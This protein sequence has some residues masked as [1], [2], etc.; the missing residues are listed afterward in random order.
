VGDGTNGPVA[1]PIDRGPFFADTTFRGA[2]RDCNWLNGWS[3]LNAWGTMSETNNTTI[4]DVTLDR[5]S[6][7][8]I[9]K[10]PTVSGVQYSV[11]TSTDNKRYN[12]ATT[13]T[14]TGSAAAIDLGASTT[15]KFVRV[16]P[17]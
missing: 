17:L 16:L 11:E 3:L 8:L 9:A 4:P 12:P 7:K 1:G 2:M 10:F 14:G 6:G 15:L 5:S 13:H